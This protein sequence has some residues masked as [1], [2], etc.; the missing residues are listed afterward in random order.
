MASGTASS[1]ELKKLSQLCLRTKGKHKCAVC[2]L[3]CE[4]A[5]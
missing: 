3:L 5:D 4:H 1:E 2:M